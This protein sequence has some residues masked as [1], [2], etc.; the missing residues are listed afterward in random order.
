MTQ[1]EA[2]SKYPNVEFL[3][4]AFI[5]DGVLL[6]NYVRLGNGVQLGNDVQLGKDVR[7]GD[8]VLL[9]NYVRLGNDVQLGKD[10]RL[11]NDVVLDRTPVQVLCHPYVVY[12]FSSTKI[13]VGCVVH[14]LEYWMQERDPRE[15]ASHPECEPWSRY[16]EAIA[17]V[18]S[19]MGDLTVATAPREEG[20]E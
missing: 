2:S 11:G 8:R 5:G 9:G 13:G 15:L 6:D 17:L 20:Q 16:R 4:T 18:A 19:H 7:L 3:G 14:C 12:P 10:V 1:K